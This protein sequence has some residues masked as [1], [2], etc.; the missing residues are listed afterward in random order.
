MSLHF[1][2]FAV[3]GAFAAALAAQVAPAAA[4]NPHPAT[5][6]KNGEETPFTA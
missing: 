4:V 5:F 6:G 1:K 3:A 2:T